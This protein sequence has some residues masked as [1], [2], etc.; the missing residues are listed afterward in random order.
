MHRSILQLAT[1]TASHG[2]SQNVCLLPATFYK[3]KHL[4]ENICLFHS[5]IHALNWYYGAA[6]HVSPNPAS[7]IFVSGRVSLFSLSMHG[8]SHWAMISK[9]NSFNF[10]RQRLRNRK[11]WRAFTWT[12]S[13]FFLTMLTVYT[14]SVN[15]YDDPLVSV[16]HHSSS[17]FAHFSRTLLATENGTTNE[18]SKQDPKFPPDLFTLEQRRHGGVIFHIIGLIYMFVAL[19]IVCDEFFI[20]ALDV[21]TEK[22]EISQDV[23]GATFMVWLTTQIQFFYTWHKHAFID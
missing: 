20:P 16:R 2:T 22:L 23:A 19:A 13:A 14:I 8:I 9:L 12:F 3:C 21:I 1:G 17:N 6:K 11:K 7:V 15:H 5:I 4:A 10:H 18:A